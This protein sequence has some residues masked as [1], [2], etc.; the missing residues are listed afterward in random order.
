[1]ASNALTACEMEGGGCL[2]GMG[3]A[4]SMAEEGDAD[5]DT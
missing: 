2:S 5:D 4:S 3:M 1:M